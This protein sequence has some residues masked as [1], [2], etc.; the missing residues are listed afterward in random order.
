MIFFFSFSGNHE[1]DFGV[2]ML[3]EL[4]TQMNFPWFLSNVY[5]KFTLQTLGHGIESRIIEWNGFRMGLMGLVEEEWLDT[6]GTV[7][8]AN[9]DYIDYVVVA[10]RLSKELRESGAELII[11]L[12]H[13]RWS[14]D[15]RLAM[16]AK[17]LDLI[18]GGH[19]HEYGAREVN[20]I[21]I[22]KSGSEF[23]HLSRID[24]RRKAHMTYEYSVERKDILKDIDEDQVIK[25]I[26]DKYNN[27]IQ[28]HLC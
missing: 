12:T 20:G 2:D 5:D 27:N 16:E 10:D 11:A 1:F 9:I 17:S 24:I 7:D 26:V 28:V 14:H 3:E 23:R 13:M 25:T 15:I 19:D 22:V 21:W 4:R 18:L 6:L 8:K